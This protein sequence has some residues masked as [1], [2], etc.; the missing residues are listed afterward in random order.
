MKYLE[1]LLICNICLFCVLGIF[2]ISTKKS[3]S[4]GFGWL[5]LFF[6]LLA[7]NFTDG[8]LLFNGTLRDF[9][10]WAFW[11][12][13]FALLYGPLLYFF[14]L[15][16]IAKQWNWNFR[17]FLHL[18]P[19]LIF[20]VLVVIFHFRTSD[21]EIVSMIDSIRNLD[22]NFILLIGIL[23]FFA[24][25]L[26]YSIFANR[27]LTRHIDQLKQYYSSIDIDWSKRMI[28]T[29]V[30]VFLISLLVAIVQYLGLKEV[31]AML[32]LSLSVISVV[33]MGRLILQAM[34][35]PMFQT[36][37]HSE[38]GN[39]PSMEELVKVSAKIQ[40]A[41]SGK[42]LFIRPE[43]TIKELAME[44]NSSDRIVSKSIN[45]LMKKNFYDLV[46]N[47]RIKEACHIFDTEKDSGL[48]VLEVLYQ[49]GF[50]SKSSF[51]TEFKKRMGQT[52]SEYR[53]RKKK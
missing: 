11:E 16:L 27:T 24:H 20:E 47:Y 40:E 18:L 43:L 15:Q 53:N 49:V 21:T 38:I 12:D 8:I 36:S 2:L 5:G 46:N 3:L 41:L 19:F 23:P 17:L 52:P 22:Q 35:Q 39:E 14:T 28:Q 25:L 4:N 31:F 45:K 6:I 33:F 51:N 1:A 29:V 48:T 37:S 32:L 42:K 9:P 44:I 10:R 13:P 34:S 30:I 26:I 7:L 50:N